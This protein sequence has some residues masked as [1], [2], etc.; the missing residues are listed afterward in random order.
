MNNDAEDFGA[1]VRERRLL[2]GLSQDELAKR[3]GISRVYLSQIERGQ[4]ANVSWPMRARIAETLGL[5]S[6]MPTRGAAPS[7]HTTLPPLPKGLQEFVAEADLAP[8]D[9]EALRH[10]QLRGK[11]PVTKEEWR[12]LYNI[13][14]SYLENK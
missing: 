6:S 11:R 10:L 8:A 7:N 14:R 12:V 13:I 4:A 5:D 1:R 3:V 2:E 9:V